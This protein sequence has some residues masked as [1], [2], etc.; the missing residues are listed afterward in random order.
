MRKPALLLFLCT[1]LIALTASACSAEPTPLPDEPG[2]IET[3]AAATI[4]AHL[5][6]V[7]GSQPSPTATRRAPATSTIAPTATLAPSSTPLPSATPIPS[8]TTVPPTPVPCNIA[9]FE[10]DVTVPDGS[11]FDPGEAFTKTWRIKNAGT[12]KWTQDFALIFVTGDA[13]S[14]DAVSLTRE[15]APG[16]SV[17]ISV[18][19]VAPSIPGS[20]RGNW[21]L[22][23][24]KGGAIGIGG[25]EKSVWV[26]I[27]VGYS[28]DE[29]EDGVLL[30]FA[31][32]Y[33]SATWESSA[34]KLDC[35]GSESAAQGFVKRLDNPALERGKDDEATLW[36]N[37]D[38]SDGGWI[39]G[40]FPPVRVEPGDE[41]IAEI[42]CLDGFEKCDVVFDVGYYFDG[43]NLRSLGEWKETYDGETTV[44]AVDL[45]PLVGKSVQFVLTVKSNGSAS[46]DAAFW[47]KPHINR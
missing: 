36:T 7:A 29:Q 14:G 41:L 18:D 27:E 2:M 37:P 21:M 6:E 11:R 24:D 25:P 43:G 33:C 16:Q 8:A 39:R 34:G 45:G 38:K 19:L 32:S 42:G 44:I 3:V 22:R 5:T 26:D 35:P 12:C 15:V 1:L 23:D 17:E 20:Y 28:E 31:T 47:L 10:A 40:T 9:K 4:S 46:D 13:M 30:N